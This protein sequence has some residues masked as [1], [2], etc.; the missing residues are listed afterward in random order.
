MDF[1]NISNINREIKNPYAGKD[2]EDNW[3]EGT[4]NIDFLNENFGEYETATEM[5]N[6]T[7]SEGLIKF[8]DY[9]VDE[10]ELEE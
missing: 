4:I 8:F 6:A 5:K 1:N 7:N 9:L 3:I 10:G 2:K